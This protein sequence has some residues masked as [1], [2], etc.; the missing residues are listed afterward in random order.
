MVKLSQ[1][2]L[3]EKLYRLVGC[4]GLPTQ[5]CISAPRSP[6]VIFSQSTET[7]D[8]QLSVHSS[9]ETTS[10]I[11]I[12]NSDD[13]RLDDTSSGEQTAVFRDLDT[14]LD[15][16]LMNINFLGVPDCRLASTSA[17]M[18][19][20]EPRRP[21]G[22]RGQAITCHFDFN[23]DGNES[24]MNESFPGLSRTLQAAETTNS[25]A[26]NGTESDYLISAY[27]QSRTNSLPHLTSLRNN[28]STDFKHTESKSLNTNRYSTI[29]ISNNY[30]DCNVADKQLTELN[31]E[32]QLQLECQKPS[33]SFMWKSLTRGDDTSIKVDHTGSDY[34]N[35]LYTTKKDNMFTGGHFKTKPS[36]NLQ[37]I[38]RSNVNLRNS[39]SEHVSFDLGDEKNQ[40]DDDVDGEDSELEEAESGAATTCDS[41][42]DRQYTQFDG[43]RILAN[44]SSYETYEKIRNTLQSDS[45]HLPSA[46]VVRFASTQALISVNGGDINDDEDVN[47]LVPKSRRNIYLPRS[48]LAYQNELTMQDKTLRQ[49]TQESGQSSIT[50][51]PHCINRVEDSVMGQMKRSASASVLLA[52]KYYAV[53]ESSCDKSL[54]SPLLLS[55]VSYQNEADCRVDVNNHTQYSSLSSSRS[56]SPSFSSHAEFKLP[57]LD[58]NQYDDDNPTA[59]VKAVSSWPYSCSLVSPQSVP[60]SSSLSVSSSSSAATSVHSSQASVYYISSC[61]KIKKANWILSGINKKHKSTSDLSVNC[62]HKK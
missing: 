36:R 32:R 54:V 14:Y 52:N 22:V 33:R 42:R 17:S 55:P 39:R 57:V 7:L 34:V 6:S 21:W 44:Y 18:S 15:A 11:D 61:G 24:V 41:V 35:L 38:K 49:L 45:V 29:T 30:T 58:N 20:E 31:D 50:H 40:D 60:L 5:Q 47:D 28:H 26:H 51:R 13:I 56:V 62:S 43:K 16:Q 12:S 25:V 9:S 59:T 48:Y 10:V 2:R 23:G 1:S 8:P 3:R 19:E 27:H 53:S 46:S 4:F 37:I